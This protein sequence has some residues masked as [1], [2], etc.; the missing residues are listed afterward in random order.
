LEQEYDHIFGDI[1]F[2][3]VTIRFRIL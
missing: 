3:Y 2:K 1:Y